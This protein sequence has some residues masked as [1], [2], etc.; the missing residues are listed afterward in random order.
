MTQKVV[1]LTCM[2]TGFFPADVH[3]EW[4]KNGQPEQNYKNTSPVLDTDGSYFMYSKLNVPKSSWEQ[5]NIYVCSVLHEALRNHH[6]TK[7]ISRSL[8][9]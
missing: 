3:V 2:I 9:N 8:G 4:E 1:S 5:G 6:T 7:A